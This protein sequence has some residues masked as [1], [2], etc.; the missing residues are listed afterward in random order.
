MRRLSDIKGRESM[1]VM[2][3]II[4][5]I[6][7]LAQD[8]KVMEFFKRNP[9]DTKD[10]DEIYRESLKRLSSALPALMESHADDFIH[11]MATIDGKPYDEYEA[12]M[13]LQ[14]LLSDLSVLMSDPMFQSFL[15]SQPKTQQ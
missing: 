1:V 4:T 11:L 9:I 5:P 6:A 2:A 12:G 15:P 14:S 7:N 13:T 3:K 10:K 8:D